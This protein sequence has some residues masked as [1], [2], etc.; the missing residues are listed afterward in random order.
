[1]AVKHVFHTQANH[2]AD[3]HLIPAPAIKL[4]STLTAAFFERLVMHIIII[5]MR[6]GRSELSVEQHF[7]FHPYKTGTQ[8]YRSGPVHL[9]AV[10]VYFAVVF[11]WVEGC[12]V[13]NPRVRAGQFKAQDEPIIDF[14][15]V[16][17][18]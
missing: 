17:E 14:P 3:L 1:M 5:P 10:G 2:W 11:V 4:P 9:G 15:V 6:E 8:R 18:L 12:R 7:V 16:T 13:V